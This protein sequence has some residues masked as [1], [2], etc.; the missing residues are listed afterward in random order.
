MTT[1]T[2]KIRELA[3]PASAA[4]VRLIDTPHQVVGRVG[5]DHRARGRA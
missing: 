2:A 5:H 3:N 1:P 4:L